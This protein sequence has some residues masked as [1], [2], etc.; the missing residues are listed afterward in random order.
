AQQATSVVLENVRVISVA[1]SAGTLN[2]PN[3]RMRVE[4]GNNPCF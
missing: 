3:F 2:V 1:T 4:Q